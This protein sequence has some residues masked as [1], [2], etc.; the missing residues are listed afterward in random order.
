MFLGKASGPV[1]AELHRLS[2]ATALQN[3]GQGEFS[4]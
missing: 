3:K 2:V 4:V 1:G